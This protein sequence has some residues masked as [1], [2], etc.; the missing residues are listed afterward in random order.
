[1]TYI[2]AE[3]GINHNGSLQIAKQLID[4]AVTAGCDAVKF[5]KRTIDVVYDNETLSIPRESPWGNTTREQK[6]GLE[7]S[8]ETYDEIDNYVRS[9]KIDWFASSW[10]LNSQKQMRKYNFKH[11]KIASAMI[12]HEEFVDCVASEKKHTFISTGMTEYKHI[13]NAIKIFESQKCDFTLFHTVS[14][15]PTKDTDCNIKMIN[16]LRENFKCKVGY[17]GHE[18]GI[19]P[20]LLAVFMGASA[21]ER[22]ITL[23]RSMYGS[24]QSASLEFDG[25]KRLVRDIRALKEIL[26]DG[27]KKFLEDEKN[28]AKKLRYFE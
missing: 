20:S 6:E 8:L 1:M 15:Y 18:V 26:G 17:S 14:T 16:S 4:M 27:E 22:H 5:Q 25:L 23:D 21:V 3:I 7:F 13:E 10:D 19:L 11:N 12:T 28:I 24:D 2:I 9:K